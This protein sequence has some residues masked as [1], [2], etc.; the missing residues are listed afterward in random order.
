MDELTQNYERG[1]Q[2]DIIILDFSKDFETIPHKSLLHKLESYGIRGPLIK[3]LEHFLTKRYMRAV[4]E[5]EFSKDADCLSGVPQGLVFGP[6]LLLV[7]IN[8]LPECVSSSVSYLQMTAC[9]TGTSKATKT[10]LPFNH[11]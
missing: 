7:H 6:I 2:T 9:F 11:I 5:G 8:D 3:R 4:V 10:T 1:D